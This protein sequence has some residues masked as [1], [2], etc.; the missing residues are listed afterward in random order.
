ME[1]FS[2]LLALCAGKSPVTGEFPAPRPVTRSFDIFFDIR[3]N[4]RMSKQSWGWWFET[5]SGSLWRHCNELNYYGRDC[6]PMVRNSSSVMETKTCKIAK[7]WNCIKYNFIPILTN[8]KFLH[9]SNFKLTKQF[10]LQQYSILCS[11]WKVS[12]GDITAM[13]QPKPPS[14]GWNW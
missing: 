5:P 4:K 6:S 11:I 2:A 8:A 12:S 7:N 3:L 13:H 10:G 1:T 14:V 9:N